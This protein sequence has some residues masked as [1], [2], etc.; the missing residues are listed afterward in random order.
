MPMKLGRASFHASRRASGRDPY[1]PGERNPAILQHSKKE[2]SHI[3]W[4]TS[5][6]R[7]LYRQGAGS[8][9]VPSPA[10]PQPMGRAKAVV[11]SAAH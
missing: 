10:L 2:N 7:H 5:W 4:N 6:R 11:A 1:P 3:F 9:L 8:A